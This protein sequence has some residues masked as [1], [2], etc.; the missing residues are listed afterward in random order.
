MQK[1]M[2]TVRSTLDMISPETAARDGLREPETAT[3]DK[4]RGITRRQTQHRVIRQL[5]VGHTGVRTASNSPP[6]VSPRE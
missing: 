3:R 6:K 1:T 4:V 2:K 5:A